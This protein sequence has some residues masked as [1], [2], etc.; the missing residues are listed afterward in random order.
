MTTWDKFIGEFRAECKKYSCRGCP[1]N[2][3]DFHSCIVDMARKLNY[4][5]TYEMMDLRTL[6]NRLDK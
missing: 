1:Y 6:K 5:E 4:I 3:G 2:E